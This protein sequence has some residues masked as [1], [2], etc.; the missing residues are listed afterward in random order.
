MIPSRKICEIIKEKEEKNE[1]YFSFEYFPPKTDKGLQNLYARLD[2]MSQY[3]PLYIDV[4]WGA[5]GSTSN[6]TPQICINAYKYS[7]LEAS[8]HI[9]CTNMPVEKIDQALDEI[10]SFGMRN[11]LALRG[12]PPRGEEWKQIEGG[13][14]HAADLVKYIRKK[15]GDWFCISVAGYPEKHVDCDTYEN[16]LKHL[17][18]K[19]D[20]GAD[21]IVTQLCYT[22]QAYLKFIKDCRNMGI[23]IPIVPGI[24]PIRSYAGTIRMC[25][26]CGANLP[27]S[28]LTDM[29][30]FKDDDEHVQAYGVEQAAKMCKELLDAGVKG[31]HFYTLNL[32]QSVRQIL[33]QLGLITDAQLRRELPWAGARTGSSNSLKSSSNSKSNPNLK[34]EAVRPIFWA[35]RPK[36]FISRTED[37]DSFPNGRWGDAGSPAFDPLSTYHLS[38]LYTN[39]IESRNQ[40]WGSPLTEQDVF[41]VFVS[42]LNGA[43]SRLPW[44]D[45]SLAEES[46]LIEKEL[47]SLNAAGY[48]TINSQPAVNAAPSEHPVHG[49]GPHGGYVYQKAYI[50]FFCSPERFNLL[51]Q[52]F[53]K[54][55][56]LDYQAVNAKGEAEGNL[57]GTA[58]VTWGV[59]PGSE[60]KQPTVVDPFVFV[61]IW[62]DEA[63]ALWKSQWASLYEEGSISRNVIDKIADT[64]YLVNI[65]D[66]NFIDPGLFKFIGELLALHSSVEKK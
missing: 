47:K 55:P 62:K 65:V 12:D 31:L 3:K 57:K 40:E 26:L 33:L 56:N 28:I 41:Q 38:R 2:H 43:I 53:A 34:S 6:L 13:F 29:E 14:A 37:W 18:E 16:D 59:W 10:K 64:Y 8:M 22:S 61:N 48:L 23:T 1:V 66:N 35:N 49:W 45:A 11:V 15:W 63:F 5:G 46:H 20:A 21:Y 54:F 4:T 51:K 19:V 17:K 58:A 27:K 24:M 44:N 9:T 36:S 60:I 42:Y 32:D 25:S 39:S 30:S 52:L 50:E 7:G